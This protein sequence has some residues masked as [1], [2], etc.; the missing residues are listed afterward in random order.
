MGSQRVITVMIH[1]GSTCLC[2]FN[3]WNVLWDEALSGMELELFEMLG[4][5]WVEEP[6]SFLGK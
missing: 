5:E 3:C 6:D 2:G 1:I 4:G